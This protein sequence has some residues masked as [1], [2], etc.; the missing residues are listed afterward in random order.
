[1]TT[2]DIDTFDVVN[3]A[4]GEVIAELP[5]TG[6]TEW[7][8]A[9]EK[10]DHAKADWVALA[11]RKRSEILYEIFQQLMADADEIA[12]II[13][14]ETG[15]AVAEAKGEV[16]YGAEY[17]RWFAE[18]AVRFPGRFNQAPNGNGHIAVTR[19]PVGVVLAITPWNFPIAMATRKIAPALAA[20]CTI[21]VKPASETPLT[22]I[23]VGEVIASVFEK[24]NID[25]GVV[26]ILPTVRDA[27]LSAQL[28]ADSRLAKITF[29]GSTRVGKILVR[30]SADNLLRSSMELGGNA[31]FVIDEAADLEAAVEGAMQAK[32][33][34]T[35]QVCIAAN[36][37]LVH[38]SIAD[39][40]TTKLSAAMEAAT[41]GPVISAAQ[42]NRIAQLVDEAVAD[43]A[44]VIIG[45]E[46]PAGEGFFYPATVLRDVPAQSRILHEEIFGPVATITTFATLEEG[47]AQ[48]NATEFGLAAYGF[49]ENVRAAQY[50]AQHLEAGMVGINRGAISDPA[51]PFG[52]IGQSG[53]GREGGTEGIEEYLSVRYI[54]LP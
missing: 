45:G 46:V 16:A 14:S 49:S 17:F 40:F 22:M 3:P 25:Q 47:V 18:E 7:F 34:N 11:P 53:F 36:R 33:R 35:G 24:H 6:T 21:L 30:Q 9:L 51:A 31:A 38:E 41:I 19:A 2:V 27:E 28:M 26:A 23:K 4:T 54:A 44:Q 12:E 52:G 1:M 39:E 5:N 8:E 10:A 13:H 43:G 48:A 20:G 42:R 29:T 32:L 37:F 50:L 15:K